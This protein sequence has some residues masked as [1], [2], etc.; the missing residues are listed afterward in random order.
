MYKHASKRSKINLS[1][2]LTFY[3]ASGPT[4]NDVTQIS[5]SSL[6]HK[7]GFVFFDTS[8]KFAKSTFSPRYVTSLR[9]ALY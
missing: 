3:K 8:N 5:E 4:T 9:N 6:C 2:R 7:N 1:S